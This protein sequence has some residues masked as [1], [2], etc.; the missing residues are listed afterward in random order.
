MGRSIP[1]LALLLALLLA[2]VALAGCATPDT[3]A[4]ENDADG[5]GLPDGTEEGL[6]VITVTT[7][8]GIENRT[9]TSDPG[10]TDTDGDGVSD[11]QEF[12]WK[13]DPRKMDT[14][15]DGLLDGKHVS[16]PLGSDAYDRFKADGI[17]ENPARQGEFLGEMS[18]CP[19]NNGLRPVEWDSDRPVADGAG[20]G[21][22]ILGWTVTTPA[23]TRDVTS[24]PC[25]YD[26][27]GDGVRDGEEQ[28][29]GTDPTAR[30]T[31]GDGVSDLVDPDPLANL[32]MRVTLQSLTFKRNP[33]GVGGGD[34][35]FKLYAA[36]DSTTVT[37]SATGTGTSTLNR[38]WLTDY[39][40]DQGM[41]RASFPASLT[42][43]AFARPGGMERPLA[44]SNQEPPNVAH[45]QWDLLKG[46]WVA[47]QSGSG[48]LTLDGADATLTLRIETV[49]A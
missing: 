16:L 9:V 22:E 8:A 32:K 46:Q 39:P 11:M 7:K 28:R 30:D 44:I 6:R 10:K 13:T 21:E 48:T 33:F 42:L 35:A 18:L 5:D 41:D 36:S 27:D 17:I 38:V 3:Q 12:L 49:R 31:D 25:T 15:G 40:D 29:L 45:L 4:T 1:S 2:T 14:D 26:S 20:D 34:V 24:D 19:Q 47:P 23:G 43:Q 37:A